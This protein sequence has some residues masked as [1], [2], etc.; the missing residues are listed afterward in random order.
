MNKSNK[1]SARLEARVDPEIKARWQQ[2]ADLEGRSLTDFIITSM[3][4]SSERVIQ[5]HQRMKLA[6]QDSRD[7]V[8]TLIEPPEPNKQLIEAARKYQEIMGE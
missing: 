5:R 4:E 6:Q 8:E 7:F 1:P 2:A 3:Q